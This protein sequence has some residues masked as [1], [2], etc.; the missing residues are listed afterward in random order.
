MAH[1]P[2]RWLQTI[3]D[4]AAPGMFL[5]D[6]HGKV[7]RANAA[8][9]RMLGRTSDELIGQ[10]SE[11]YTHPEERDTRQSLLERLG[12]NGSKPV[13]TNRRYLKPDGSVVW[14]KLS[15]AVVKEGGVPVGVVGTTTDITRAKTA[16]KRLR[17]SEAR[18]RE[19][20]DAMPQIVWSASPD[21]HVDYFNRR[22][23]EYT[24]QAEGSVG[25]EAW[26]PVLTPDVA[27]LVHRTWARSLETGEVYELEIPLRR[28]DGA[29]RWVL[30][31]GLPVKDEAGRIV[32][33]Y[34]TNTDIHDRKLA[35]A[36]LRDSESRFR[37]LAELS[38]RTR[39]VTDPDA[40]LAAIVETLGR[41]LG[42]SCCALAEV[43]PA[44]PDKL[45]IDADHSE[46]CL[47]IRGSYAASDF[48]A[49]LLRRLRAG[50]TVTVGDGDAGLPDPAGRVPERWEAE[51]LALCPLV[52]GGRL[53]A[54]MVVLKDADGAKSWKP[55][56]LQLVGAVLERG[57]SYVE[58][59]RAVQR[60]T[61]TQH[62]I[63]DIVNGSLDA[64]V[65]MDHEG[66]VIEWNPAAERMFGYRRDEA[67]GREMC[68]LI[69]P[70]GMRERHRQGLVRFMAT[71]EAA[72]LGR[73][74]E[75]VG[76][77]KDGSTLP[78]ELTVTPATGTDPPAFN[79]VVRDITERL[80]TDRQ[81]EALLELERAARAES[82]LAGRMKD[83]FLATLS[84][85]LRTPLHAVLGWSRM[86]SKQDGLPELVGEGLETIQR[87][88]KAQSQIIEDLL[89]MS[90]I[91]SGKVRL[92]VG[93]VDLAGTLRE[94]IDTV[95]PAAA[96]RGVTL[97][98]RMSTPHEPMRGDADRLKQVFWNL[99]S[100]AVK[101]TP[102]GG[103]VSV[104][105]ERD[106]GHAAVRVSDTGKGIDAAFLPHV[107]DR[108]RQADAATTRSHGG[109]GLGLSIVKQLV[110]LH[111]G[112]V[113]V[114]SDGDGAGTSF[115]VS[116]P[117]HAE[118]E[119]GESEPAEAREEASRRVAPEAG[120]DLAGLR[121]LVVD[122][123]ADAR[124]LLRRVLEARGVGVVLAG[125]A[126][127]AAELVEAQRF[128]LIVSDI[129]MPGEDGFSFIRRVRQMPAD[130]NGSTPAIAL[131]AYA[132]VEDRVKAM[133]AGFQ[134][135]VAKPVDTDE[136]L[137]LIASLTGRATS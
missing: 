84:H 10:N 30:A 94:A 1:E 88:A 47:S 79:G 98:L 3:F 134:M 52:R 67:M 41:R 125:S 12:A 55:R 92:N 40:I 59:A 114:H 38:E 48:D 91:I 2:Q 42:T 31:R 7:L 11:A 78:V 99:L 100:N 124:Q 35:E 22:W 76:L 27:E 77:R 32:R 133:V 132:R 136:L 24:G 45:R 111:G 51:L 115:T 58:H 95:R 86:L 106:G 102:A 14:V 129:G 25:A 93:P 36:A 69:V 63:A 21:G 28:A 43:D 112:A 130:L 82:E 5:T 6:M 128:D 13:K 101:F 116:L 61:L 17:E 15:L 110:E 37:V 68:E 53:S 26:E 85:E 87:S 113:S 119:T 54:M 117:L 29:F 74:L 71:G 108:F 66:K 137:I 16:A 9:C 121:V 83:E 44:D 90:R 65:C 39:D 20:A 126:A 62:R 122:D 123:E 56:E 8:F 70:E 33:W 18:F 103:R 34:G 96:A 118:H 72:V 120:P 127:T 19:L 73:R 89:D 105:L 80:E 60:L 135:H 46:D 64:I 50:E 104:D 75:L 109:L 4:H 131:T 57:W 97:D 81:R 107:F 23:Y 49:A